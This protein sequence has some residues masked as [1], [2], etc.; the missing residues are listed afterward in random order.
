MA[1]KTRKVLKQQSQQRALQQA[2]AN[3]NAVDLVAA[4]AAAAPAVAAAPTRALKAEIT[5]EQDFG[6]VKSDVRRSLTLAGLFAAT[7][8]VLS[9]VLR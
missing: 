1:K 6:F 5:D 9:F 4:P 2:V 3:V 7:M 8:I